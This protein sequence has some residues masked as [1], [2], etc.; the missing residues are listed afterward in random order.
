RRRFQ[1]SGR[2]VPIYVS[3]RKK[4]PEAKVL[5]LLRKGE[6]NPAVAVDDELGLMAVLDSVAEVKLFLTHLTQSAMRAE[7]FMTLEEIS[8]TLT[9]G[10]HQGGIGSSRLTPMFK[11]FARMGGMR[12]EFIIHSN[13]T[14]LNYIYQRDISHDE[15]EI[16]RIFDSGVAEMLF[17]QDIYYLDM[18]D[19]KERQ[20]RQC[21]RQIE[22]G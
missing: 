21:R 22:E 18:A 11:F 9:G 1:D 6:E 12:V 2:E 14:Y 15:Y 8:D 19:I 10:H 16:K 13:K 3:I 5:K 7:S 20:L 17:P 4:P